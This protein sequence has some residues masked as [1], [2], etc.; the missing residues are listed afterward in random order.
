MALA[1]VIAGC[2]TETGVGGSTLKVRNAGQQARPLN[3]IVRRRN[4]AHELIVKSATD[5]VELIRAQVRFRL[6]SHN[7]ERL[8]RQLALRIS[9]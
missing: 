5:I 4:T 3:C 9:W 8:L 7:C 2:M 1:A 6:L